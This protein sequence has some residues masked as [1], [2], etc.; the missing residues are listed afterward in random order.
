MKAAI[1]TDVTKCIGCEECVAAC[2]K[3]NSLGDDLP[4]CDAPDDG[5]SATRWTSVIRKP[6]KHYVRKQCRHCLNPACVSVCPVGALQKTSIGAVTY[7]STKCIGCRYCMMACPYGVPRYDWG[8]SV[9]YVRKCILCYDRLIAGKQPACTEAC[10]AEATIFGDRGALLAEGK[11]RIQAAPKKYIPM[12]FGEF[13]IGGTSVLY[14]SDIKLD[15]LGWQKDLGAEPL[16][17]LTW[18]AI[19]KVPSMFFGVGLLMSGVYWVIDRRIK[20]QKVRM[21]SHEKA[22]SEVQDDDK[23]C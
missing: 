22:N 15:F 5:L 12:V 17:E 10:P 14:L 8:K 19:N 11:R 1:L 7:D 6:K 9:P 2:K 20:L 21:E 16:P 23:G 18:N 4:V 3:T 13:E